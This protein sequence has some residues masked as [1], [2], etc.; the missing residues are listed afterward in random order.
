VANNLHSMN[1][2][3]AKE[4]LKTLPKSHEGSKVLSYGAA[5]LAPGELIFP[6]DL[7]K[8]L[9]DLISAL[10]AKPIQHM[11]SSIINSMDN[12]KIFNGP[13]F[14]VDNMNVEDEV[15]MQ[16]ISREFRRAIVSL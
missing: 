2:E 5:Y 13:L 15:D 7:S 8:K 1:Y 9:E 10:Y 16:I 4:Y 6:P 3:Q 12:R 14:N 11:Q